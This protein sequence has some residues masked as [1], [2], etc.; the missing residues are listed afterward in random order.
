MDNNQ[1]T[2]L[3]R[4][5]PTCYDVAEKAGV[6]Q[7]TVSRA[8]AGHSSV[9][10]QTRERVADIARA[11]GYQ[12]DSV[13]ASVRTGRIDRIAVIV[14]A[15]KGAAPE[16]CNPFHHTLLAAICQAA[17]A[18]GLET[19]VSFQSH[20]ETLCGNYEEAR[21]AAGLIVIG[22]SE[23]QAAW[24]YFRQIAR[25]GANIVGWG[26][27]H[28]D[29]RWVRADNAMG[30]RLA[31]RHLLEAGCRSIAFLGGGSHAPPQFAERFAA[32]QAA[33]AEQGLVLHAL[34]MPKGTSRLHQGE[35]AGRALLATLP[36][37]DGVIA[38]NDSLA[39]G[40]QNALRSGGALGRILLIGF[41]GSYEARHANPP[42]PSIAPDFQIAGSIL[43]N[44]VMDRQAGSAPACPRSPV[45]MMI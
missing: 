27:P 30:G 36:A 35:K 37:C 42:I 29:M 8:L 33:L 15:R 31:A 28:E 43:L 16:H 12:T 34:D 7:S 25:G 19:L 40:L 45:G 2:T 13:A 41:D 21:K 10:A 3:R 20:P 24:R 26:T 18:R 9:S 6:S 32:S 44:A 5:R 11:L 17:S 14:L 22:T 23:N 38:A 1:T 39:L 4:F